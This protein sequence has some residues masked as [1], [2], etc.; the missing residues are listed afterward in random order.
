[1]KVSEHFDLREFVCPELYQQF[2]DSAI[3]FVDNRII[4]IA[5]YLRKVFGPLTINNWHIEREYIDS[6]VRMFDCITG[7]KESQHKFGRAVDLKSSKYTSAEIF[8]YIKKNFTIL[9]ALGLTTVENIEST[10][11]WNHVD[12]RNTNQKELLIVNPKK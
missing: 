10:P 12:C 3:W 8:E 7:G 4:N 6:G 2:E 1:M 9:S 5:E 11:T